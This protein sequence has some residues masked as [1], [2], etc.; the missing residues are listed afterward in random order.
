[1]PVRGV[2]GLGDR[3]HIRPVARPRIAV[4]GK[5]PALAP[6]DVARV[7]GLE[8]V[9]LQ[10]YD[11]GGSSIAVLGRSNVADADLAA[12]AAAH[13][14]P[15]PTVERVFTR[16]GLDPGPGDRLDAIEAAIDTQWAAAMAPGAAVRLVLASPG[17]D[18]P[19]ALLTAVDERVADV[20]SISFGLCEPFADRLLAEFFDDQYARAL[21]QGQTVLV[22]AGDGGATDCAPASPVLAVNALASSTHAV[23]VGGTVLDPLFDPSGDATGYGGEAAWSGGGGGSSL[24]FARPSHQDGLLPLAGRMLPDLA[25]AAA[26]N[27]PGY[28]IVHDGTT[29]VVG[30]TSVGAPVVAALVA[31]ANQRA[32]RSVGAVLPTLY[33]A[34]QD[35]AAVPLRD[36]TAGSN[37]HPATLGFDLAT[38][39]GSPL[40]EPFTA[41][42]A[43]AAAAP[44]AIRPLATPPIPDTWVNEADRSI[45]S[46]M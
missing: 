44:S 6:A 25:L 2:L 10:G 20:L 14:V 7:Y 43:A 46:R 21:S 18:I 41:T 22:S 15:V 4:P 11:G 26:P 1:M 32:G 8:A 34:M 33:G 19:E 36:V 13:G 37:D 16:P 28:V 23:A 39:W 30:G 29:S 12:F 42:L 40:A 31:L 17:D 24:F 3:F 27:G 5:E 38:G 35:G 9:Y 45:V